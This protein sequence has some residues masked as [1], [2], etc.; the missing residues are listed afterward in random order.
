MHEQPDKVIHDG[1]NGTHDIELNWFCN[2][3]NLIYNR[4]G[5]FLEQLN[6]NFHPV[7]QVGFI[8]VFRCSAKRTVTSNPTLAIRSK[9]FV[10]AYYI[11]YHYIT[12]Q[13][14]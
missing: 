7:G 11:I 13:H 9:V 3:F 5:V 12:L 10:L 14:I 6:R 1:R 4:I 8:Q 2:L